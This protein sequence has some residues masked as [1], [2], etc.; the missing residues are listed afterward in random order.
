MK[1][2]LL[3]LA[4]VCATSL[5]FAQVP[6]PGNDSDHGV[7]RV[8]GLIDAYTGNLAFSTGDLAVAGAVGRNGLTWQRHATSRTSQTENLFGLGH[9]WAHSWQWEMVAAG[10][11]SQGR[12]VLSVRQPQGWVHRFTETSP[13]QWWPA[14]GVRDR[15]VSSGNT[16]TVQRR[17]AGEV[18]FT[19]TRSAQGDTFTL[20]AMVDAEGLATKLSFKAGR[21]AQIT[22]PAGRWL[23]LTYGALAAPGAVKG[24]L[25]F[26]VISRVMASDGQSV[27][28]R[29][30]FPAGADYP[31]LAGVDYPDST[32]AVYTYAAPRPGARMLLN[33]AD[34][35][36][37]AGV[38][39]GRM[40]RYR[41]EPDAA[42]GQALEVLVASDGT[43]IS[44]LAADTRGGRNYAVKEDN[45]A[46]TFR[47]FLPGGNL[48]ERIDA[49]GYSQKRAY[50]AGGRGFKTA[51]TDEL[52]KIIRYEND[53]GGQVLKTTY[54]DATT[55][56]WQRDVRGRVL[57]ET[58][59]LGETRST[60]RDAAG[61][62]TAVR[63]PD[64]ATEA[65]TYNPF[66]Q[67]LTRKD[68]AGAVTTLGYNTRG[69]RIGTTD[70]LGHRTA[71]AYDAQDRVASSTD[72]RGNATRYERD[73]AGRVTRTIF[74]DGATTTTAYDAYGQM[75]KNTDAAGATLTHVF[76]VFG[77]LTSTFDALGHETRTEYAGSGQSAAPFGRPVRNTSAAGRVSTI[78]YDA[79][80]RIVAQTKAAGTRLAATTRTAYDARGNQTSV[81]DPRGKTV[82]FFYDDRG[83]RT[84]VMNALTYAT[85]TTY[86]AAG[87]KLTETDPKGNATSWTYDALGREVAK[88]DALKHVTRREY[89]AA[90]RLAA[91]TDA[92]GSTYR[93]ETD[94][95]GRATALG[96]PDG[97]KETTAYDGAG[98]KTRFTNRAGTSRIFVYDRRNREVSS[99]WSDGSQIITKA[100]DNA[101]RMTLEDNGVSKIS[102]AFDPAGQLALETQDLS[103]LV[104]GGASDPAAR[105]VSYTYTAD[106]QRETLGYP[107]GSFVKYT[108]NARGQLDGILGDGVP[109]PIASYDYDAAGNA[110][111]MPRENAT[112]TVMDY[113]AANRMTGISD[114]SPKRS[115]LSELD[116]T[117]DEANNRTATDAT[118]TAD[119]GARASTSQRDAYRYDATYQVTGA[120][121]ASPARPPGVPVG[122]PKSAVRFRY[123]AVGNRVEVDEDGKVTRYTANALNQYT[124]VGEFAPAY[125]RNGNLASMGKWL[126]RYDAMNRLTEA[127]D[128]AMTAKFFYDAKNRCV[129]RSYNG[130]VTLD[131]YD[132]WNMVEERDGRGAQ[133]ARYV[134]GRKIDEIVVMVNRFG[135]FYPH[136]DVLGNV[137][138]LTDKAGKLAERYSYSVEGQVAI[139]DAAGTELVASAVGNRW[140]FTGREWLK[141]VGLY[142]Y[143]NRL[144]SAG[145]GR[146]IQTDPIRFH[147]SDINIYR[148]VRNSP[149]N[150]IDPTGLDWLIPDGDNYRLGRDGSIIEPNGVVGKFL[151]DFGPAMHTMSQ[152]HDAFVDYMVGCRGLPDFLVNIPTIPMFYVAAV[153]QEIINSIEDFLNWLENFFD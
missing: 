37:G 105:T 151:S 127:S 53:A 142:D 120:D 42:A 68:R 144:Y 88:T 91:L 30:E 55:R 100:Y 44:G 60:T 83:R 74:A 35:P 14:P 87:R 20:A 116:Y 78:T 4:L 117:Y 145:L 40:F 125:D 9:N 57:A 34:D 128:G 135:T 94:A 92:K 8:Q 56:S 54:P 115:P 122:P 96:Y 153:F 131:T 97:S 101:G 138:M 146:F 3:P 26:T 152:N 147:A 85:T 114:Y 136:R 113:D 123:D 2:L 19:R 124:Q 121:Y 25:P 150:L 133:V 93:F 1:T 139:R 111:Q 82:Q 58:N 75:T 148:Y 50:D 39:R 70:A 76:D 41:S 98:N 32:R 11:D 89:D 71:T 61:R 49:L 107:D 73:A 5:G 103:P 13:G 45:G 95:L 38:L 90:G 99:V 51:D 17:D 18:S 6:Y 27:G 137:T 43:A 140:M 33:R 23:K 86:D 48:S 46:T 141:E 143:R 65:M 80:G 12:S 15:V 7:T 64:G 16:F 10:S 77:R 66:G 118:L 79:A 106:G 130:A 28:Y 21:L 62:V 112:T 29:Y 81:T 104:T 22:E 132:N 134:H 110:T 47:T 59:E 119:T 129:A 69:L 126:Y 109:P 36:R 102:Y 108:Y 31:V 63:H 149:L 67:M 24:A 72:A 84:K 52:G